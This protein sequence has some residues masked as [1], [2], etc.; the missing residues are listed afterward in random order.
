MDKHS[1]ATALQMVGRE[2]FDLCGRDSLQ[3]IPPA[4][5]PCTM[6]GTIPISVSAHWG[7][8]PRS[9]PVTD[10][11]PQECTMCMIARFS[12]AADGGEGGGISYSI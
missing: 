10:S 7:P 6:A 2:A 5:Q 1:P 4:D 9:L 12:Q 8:S 11:K 3:V